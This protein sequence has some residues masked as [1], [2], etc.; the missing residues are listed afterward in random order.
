[1]TTITKKD[2]V[3]IPELLKEA[4]SG[5]FAQGNVIMG[6]KYA[7]VGAA[8]SNGTM[9]SKAIGDSIRIPYFNTIGDFQQIAAD[10]DAASIAALAQTTETASVRHDALAFE[11]TRWAQSSAGKSIYQ[12]AAEQIVKACGRK[13]DSLVTDAAAASPLVKSLYSSS[14][15]R[16]LDY[17]A[18]VDSMFL[19]GDQAEDIAALAIHSKT[20]ADLLKLKDGTG[21][22]LLTMPL[23]G[24][25]ERFM[26]IPLVV[27]D[28]VPLTGSSMGSVTSAGTSPPTATLSGTPSG[29]WNLKLDV[30]V[31]G[32][33]GAATFRFSTDGGNTWSDALTTGASVALV[34][35]AVDSLVG[36]NGS[37]GLTVAFANASFSV[38]NTYVANASLKVRSLLLQKNALAF[39]Y[40]QDAMILKTDEDIL[41]DADIGA[42]HLY[43]ATK[44]YRRRPGSVRPGVVV[45]EHNVSG[46]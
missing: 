10:G 42:M 23:D 14:V 26:G 25:L 24:G 17:D 18:V 20:K 13:M 16:T 40:N 37:T 41:A 5:A 30:P 36:N 22:P 46:Y 2:N 27:S 3:F 45:I 33:R 34:D 9:P 15:P 31:G 43:S 8:V 29:P 19:W 12:E 7:A 21:R 4:V 28:L 38:D 44:L 1:M 6:S 32:A 35:T 39:W 11:V